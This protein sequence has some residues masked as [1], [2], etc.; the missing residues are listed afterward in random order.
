MAGLNMATALREPI[1][2]ALHSVTQALLLDPAAAP[3]DKHLAALGSV[4]AAYEDVM[5]AITRSSSPGYAVRDLPE[6]ERA[7]YEA[8]KHQF[9]MLQRLHGAQATS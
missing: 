2:V 7:H 3:T 6:D 4:L 1:I 8:A 5:Q 9:G